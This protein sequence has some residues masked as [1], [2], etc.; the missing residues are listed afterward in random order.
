MDSIKMKFDQDVM[1]IKSNALISIAAIENNLKRMKYHANI[2]GNK[3][4]EISR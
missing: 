1:K 4:A 2:L 3:S